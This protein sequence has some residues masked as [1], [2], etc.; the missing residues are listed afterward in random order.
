MI[1][2]YRVFHAE[3]NR[4]SFLSKFVCRGRLEVFAKHP[5]TFTPGNSAAAR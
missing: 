2:L 3:Q 1:G 4:S 5:M